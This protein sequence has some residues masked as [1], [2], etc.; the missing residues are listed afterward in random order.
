MF[1][2]CWW[3]APVGER[4]ARLFLVV[5]VS[6][7]SVR[8]LVRTVLRTAVRGTHGLQGCSTWSAVASQ[9]RAPA[10]PARRPSWTQTGRTRPGP[11]RAFDACTP[12]YER[13]TSSLR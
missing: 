13:L 7:G 8:G 9:P 10:P 6:T 3:G 2:R 4:P 12:A 5:S 11:E 1:Q